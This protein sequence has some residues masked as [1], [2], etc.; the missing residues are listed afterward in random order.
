M[1][2]ALSDE[3]TVCRSQL[4]K[5]LASAV[6]LCFESRGTRDHIL[7]SQWTTTDSILLLYSVGS[8]RQKT[9]FISLSKKTSTTQRLV[10]FQES[11]STETCFADPFPS[12]GVHF[13]IFQAVYKSSRAVL[14]AEPEESDYDYESM[15]GAVM[16]RLQATVGAQ[17]VRRG[18]YAP[19]ALGPH[20]EARYRPL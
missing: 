20:L 16:V 19:R 12:I 14:V 8:D 2:G 13:T 10:G 4:L 6:F 15:G 5:A 9:P 7:L 11:I 1:W 3:R 18:A 17:R